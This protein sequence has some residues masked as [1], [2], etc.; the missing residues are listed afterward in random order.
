MTKWKTVIGY[1]PSVKLWPIIILPSHDFR[2][3]MRNFMNSLVFLNIPHGI[4]KLLFQWTYNWFF[5]DLMI[6]S[7]S[8]LSTYMPVMYELWVVT[9]QL[10]VLQ[11]WYKKRVNEV[12]LHKTKITGSHYACIMDNDEC[13]YN[14]MENILCMYK[15]TKQPQ[16]FFSKILGRWIHLSH[17]CTVT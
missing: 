13:C 12:C 15:C 14:L 17:E 11:L 1:I 9:G 16:K 10:V 3:S 7:D 5:M 4:P 6:Q 8:F 2:S